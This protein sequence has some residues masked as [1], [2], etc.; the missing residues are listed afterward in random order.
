MERLN[1]DNN[2]NGNSKRYVT[3]KELI[4]YVPLS[5]ATVYELVRKRE[6]PFIP[7]GRKI[8]FDK[9]AIDRWMQTRMVKSSE[10]LAKPG[11]S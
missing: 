9:E 1:K 2:G 11:S 10:P 7:F 3:A 5:T 4:A 6:M 8:I